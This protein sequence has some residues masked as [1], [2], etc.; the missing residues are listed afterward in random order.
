MWFAKEPSK[1]ELLYEKAEERRLKGIEL[2]GAKTHLWFV[3]GLMQDPRTTPGQYE[4]LAEEKS[5]TQV[6]IDNL[7]AEYA[8]A[9]VVEHDADVARALS[10]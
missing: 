8:E 3:R 4:K 5:L 1:M 2:E 10:S 7:E 9:L 6:I